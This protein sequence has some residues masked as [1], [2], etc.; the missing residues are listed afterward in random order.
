MQTG[1]RAPSLADERGDNM[2]VQPERAISVTYATATFSTLAVALVLLST[3]RGER[4]RSD[5]RRS[6]VGRRRL[7]LGVLPVRRR[8]TDAEND[9]LLRSAS[10]AAE[11]CSRSVYSPPPTSRSSSCS[12]PS[13]NRR[14]GSRR[15][16]GTSRASPVRWR[17]SSSAPAMYKPTTYLTVSGRP[18]RPPSV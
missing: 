12:P 18:N 17:G 2:S 3:G 15:S 1:V 6:R 16:S 11:R 7:T 14:H 5:V 8:M 13:V 9:A 10:S 4:S